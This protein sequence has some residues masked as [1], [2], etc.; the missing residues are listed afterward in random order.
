MQVEKILPGIG[1]DRFSRAFLRQWESRQGM[2]FTK[3][4][5]TEGLLERCHVYEECSRS[6]ICD[7]IHL[8]M[9][10]RNILSL[11]PWHIVD[12]SFTIYSQKLRGNPEACECM[13]DGECTCSEDGTRIC[14]SDVRIHWSYK[15]DLYR[16]V[17][18]QIIGCGPQFI[19]SLLNLPTD[20]VIPVLRQCMQLLK[21]REGKYCCFDD[22]MAQL[23]RR[24]DGGAMAMRWQE[25]EC[26]FEVCASGRYFTE[27]DTRTAT[28]KNRQW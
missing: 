24:W 3:R 27:G 23:L 10:Y 7:I 14:V 20:T 11:L 25:E 1:G 28:L 4:E 15:P 2:F 21:E 17:I 18:D 13:N 22:V 12:P 9:V 16:N 8:Q 26:Y 5:W 6:E 19:L